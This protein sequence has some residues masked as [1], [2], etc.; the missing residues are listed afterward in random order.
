MLEW[1]RAA[2]WKK[3][4]NSDSALPN[5]IAVSPDGETLYVDVYLGDEV[6]KI[7]RRS[8]ELLGT[9]ASPEPRQPELDRPTGSCWSRRR[10]RR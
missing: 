2:G 5:G 7:A 8:G 9:V 10:T 6:R 1:Q 4:P 3:V